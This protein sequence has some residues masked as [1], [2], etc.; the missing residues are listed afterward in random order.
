MTAF[1]KLVSLHKHGVTHSVS[2]ACGCHPSYHELG[3]HAPGCAA[4]I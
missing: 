2:V 3:V 4:S 1:R